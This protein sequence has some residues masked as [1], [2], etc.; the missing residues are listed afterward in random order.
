MAILM[1]QLMQSQQ[2]LEKLFDPIPFQ[3][4]AFQALAEDSDLF[5]LI[6]FSFYLL[7]K[8]VRL[9]KEQYGLL[10]QHRFELL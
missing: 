6:V 5:S 9:L 3:F 2:S 8:I 10:I 1:H 4:K 7:A